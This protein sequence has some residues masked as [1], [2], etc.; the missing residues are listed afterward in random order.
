MIAAQGLGAA[1][2]TIAKEAGVSNGSLFTYFENKAELMNQLYIELKTEMAVVGLEGLPRDSDI[3]SQF[4]HTW[5][6]WARWATACPE[7]R[8]ALAHLGVADDVTPESRKI[9]QQAMLGVATLLDRSRKNGALRNAPLGFVAALMS[10]LAD[11][12]MDYMIADPANAET[13]CITGF[14]GLWR[15]LN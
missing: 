11:T 10:A 1:T 9:G 5:R 13:H 4:L 7:K 15:M 6:N 3:R 12:T 2:A 14:D 8:R